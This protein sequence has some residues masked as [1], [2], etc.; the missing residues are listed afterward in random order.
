[1][2]CKAGRPWLVKRAR[3]RMTA[4]QPVVVEEGGFAHLPLTFQHAEQAGCLPM[5]HR[6]PF[7]RFSS[8]R[9]QV[10]GLVLVTRDAR[11]PLYRVRTMA[12]CSR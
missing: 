12:A 8:S 10:E 5:H 2:I 9:P 7:D 6:D 1:M 4:G 11:I 3:G